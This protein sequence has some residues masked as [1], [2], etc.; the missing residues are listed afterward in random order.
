MPREMVVIENINHPGYASRVDAAKYKAARVAMLRILPR[1]APGLTQR[2]GPV[3]L[4]RLER[5]T[6][7]RLCFSCS[8]SCRFP[9][10]ARVAAEHTQCLS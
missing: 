1:K 6:L 3:R 4:K 10:G 9:G 2:E 5:A 7:H 8:G